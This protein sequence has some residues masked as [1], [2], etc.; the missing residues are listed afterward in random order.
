[1]R[2]GIY[3]GSGYKNWGDDAQLANTVLKLKKRKYNDLVIFSRASYIKNITNTKINPSSHNIFKRFK[4]EKQLL[5]KFN[6]LI[7]NYNCSNQL[8]PIEQKF[9]KSIARLDVLFFAG[10]GTIN[11][12]RMKGVCIFLLPFV[13]AKKMGKKVIL[14]GQGI[15]P[16]A[17]TSYTSLIR[18]SL[19]LVDKIFIRDFQSGEDQLRK[20]GVTIPIIQGIDNAFGYPIT[21]TKFQYL[22]DK[23][24][25]GIN[26][27]QSIT[28][29]IINKLY[30]LALLLKEKGYTPIFNYF[31]NE[32]SI[33]KKC[34]RNTFNS[35]EFNNPSEIAEFY[36]YCKMAIGMRYHSTIFCLSQKVPHVNLHCNSYQ[37][38]KIEAIEE[39]T[40]LTIGIDL[41]SEPS[42]EDILTQLETNLGNV[43]GFNKVH[44]DW[45]TKKYID[46]EEL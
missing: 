19:N 18:D 28:V 45:S 21:T 32:K 22:K 29:P 30:N 26:V 46:I 40:G 7:N 31:Q 10:S 23:K 15:G 16:L 13:L 6:F 17:N 41:M 9:I 3:N 20:I 12:R 38:L 8:V 35:V 4:T 2:I 11:T 44:Q 5:E 14:S 33:I 34:C 27:S 39:V 1:M 37:R 24:V 36:S 25:V 43:D 42:I